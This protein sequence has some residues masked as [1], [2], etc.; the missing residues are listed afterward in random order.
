[1]LKLGTKHHS[2]FTIQEEARQ[3]RSYN[4]RSKMG[5]SQDQFMA[6]LPTCPIR[7]GAPLHGSKV[8]FRAL[9][10]KNFLCAFV[11][12]S[13]AQNNF[14]E[15]MTQVR[16]PLPAWGV[17]GRSR[18]AAGGSSMAGWFLVHRS[19][20]A[21]QPVGRKAVSAWVASVWYRANFSK[22]PC[23]VDIWASDPESSRFCEGWA[24]VRSVVAKKC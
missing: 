13:E 23:L 18:P 10:A 19:D 21:D 22:R 20:G 15:R 5:Y 11:D 2:Q 24:N 3:Q 4:H 6:G 16:P 12:E 17:P 1:M 7:N 14:Q 8:R 9:Y